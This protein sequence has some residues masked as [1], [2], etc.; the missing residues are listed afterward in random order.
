[1]AKG[2]GV[3][4][5][6]VRQ[7][8]HSFPGIVEGTSWGTPG[9]RLRG[10]LLARLQEDDETL[11]LSSDDRDLL[12]D[13]DP[14]AFYVTPHYQDYPRVLIRLTKVKREMLRGLIEKAWRRVASARQIKEFDSGAFKAPKLKDLPKESP[15][16]AISKD[17]TARHL[18]RTRHACGQLP[19]VEE[20][21]AWG[22]PTFRA[23]GKMFAMFVSNHHGDGRIALWLN[24]APGVQQMLVDAAPDKFFVP[25]YTGKQGWVGLH[26]D[27]ND[28]DEVAFHLSQAY[29]RVAHPKLIATLDAGTTPLRST[30]P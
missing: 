7:L 17:E 29:R 21:L 22:A 3:D 2:T 19:E 6:T 12:I 26:L 5:A 25:P 15:R 1:M 4:F 18:E 27:R 13:S 8:M 30:R 20:K 9:F 24:V 10:R 14:D 16:K 11:V 28:D 23:S